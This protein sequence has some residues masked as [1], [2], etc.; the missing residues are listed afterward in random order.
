MRST[1]GLEW[2]ATLDIAGLMEDGWRPTPFREFIVKI[3]S[4]CDLACDYCYMYE[5]AD[6]SWRDRP[7]SMT[8]EIAKHAAL[9]IGEHARHHR[10]RDI[11]VILHGGEPLLAG[12]QLMSYLVTAVRDEAGSEVTV[13]ASVQTNAVGLDDSYLR[14]FSDLG[15]TVG[16]SLDGAENA[17]NRHRRFRSGR[18]SHAAVT[19]ALHRLAKPQYR[20]LFNGL[21]CTI[22]LRNDPITTYEALLD[23]QPPK[24][25]FL[26]PHGT[27]A[28]PPAGRVPGSRDTPY[29]DWLITIFDYWYPAARTRIRLFEEIMSLLLGGSS[30]SEMVGLSP[31]TLIV[32]ETDGSLEQGDVLKAA[33]HGAPATGLHVIQDRLD[34]ALL[35]PGVAARQLGK[36]ALSAECRACRIHRVCGGGFY[37]HRYRPGSGFANPSVYC[38]DLMRLIDHIRSVVQADIN[39]HLARQEII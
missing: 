29:A 20:H 32:I 6:Q 37:A 14:L 18:G 26:L 15:V 25:D 9:R 11:S 12:P 3:H 10:L 39:R 28:V 30:S 36:R 17:H 24:I 19:A 33:Y 4:R 13:D 5:M 27:W 34:D 8:Y 7:R 38:P 21:L 16:V 31:S 2:P 35:L 23:F 22:D 1:A